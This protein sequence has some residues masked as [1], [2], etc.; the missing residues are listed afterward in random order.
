MLKEKIDNISA[1]Q[2]K[3]KYLRRKYYVLSRNFR[4]YQHNANGNIVLVQNLYPYMVHPMFCRHYYDDKCPK[5]DCPSYYWN[6]KYFAL[7]KSLCDARHARNMAI[8][9]LV[10]IRER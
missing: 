8:L 4:C 5:I 10:G 3:V 7:R 9:S 2:H 1:A 6:K